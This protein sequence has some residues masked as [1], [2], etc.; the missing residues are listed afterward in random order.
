MS[1]PRERSLVAAMVPALANMPP[2]A[3]GAWAF[4]LL[5]GALLGQRSAVGW[6]GLGL[7]AWALFPGVPLFAVAASGV[8]A[9][10]RRSLVLAAGAG[11]LLSSLAP[12][13]LQNCGALALLLGLSAL[14]PRGE[15]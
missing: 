9:G 12:P 1:N 5:L 4:A 10:D 6:L 8:L 14:L 13:A 11:A 15:P 3:T 2:E 7:A